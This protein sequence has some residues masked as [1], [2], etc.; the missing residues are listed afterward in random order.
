MET[1]LAP[2]FSDASLWQLGAI[3]LFTS[4]AHGISRYGFPLDSTLAVA[5]FKDVR[6]AV[7]VTAL[8]N[9]TGKLISLFKGANWRASFGKYLPVAF[10]VV[11]GTL[12]GTRL[13]LTMPPVP[14]LLRLTGIIVD[15]LK[16]ESFKTLH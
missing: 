3:A 4:L 6:T 9:I 8:R 12:I 1:H 11:L 13:I 10:Y 7:I 14:L 15:C 2:D 5:L 16:Q